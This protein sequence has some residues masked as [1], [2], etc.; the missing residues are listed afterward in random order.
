MDWNKDFK[1]ASVKERFIVIILGL[2][3]GSLLAV[4]AHFIMPS[5]AFGKSFNCTVMWVNTP[6]ENDCNKITLLIECD[7]NITKFIHPQE[8]IKL[9]TIKKDIEGC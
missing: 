9:K 4:A 1:D 7:N 2:F 8:R 6:P 3:I 5:N